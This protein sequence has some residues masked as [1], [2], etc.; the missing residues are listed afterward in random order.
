MELRAAEDF[1]KKRQMCAPDV[2]LEKLL[3][4]GGS[5]GKV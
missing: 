4:Q 5:V 2:V 3:P 1:P